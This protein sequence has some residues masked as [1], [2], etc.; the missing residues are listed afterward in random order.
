MARCFSQA[1]IARNGRIKYF[2]WKM[3]FDF[4][5][6]LSTQRSS[7][8]YHGRQDAEQFQSWVH[9]LADQFHRLK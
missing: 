4:F 1:N 3:L 5:M 2:A 9:P 8:I 6:D 7:R